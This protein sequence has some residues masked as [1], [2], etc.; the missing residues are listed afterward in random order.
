MKIQLAGKFITL[1]PGDRIVTPITVLNLTQHHAIFIGNYLRRPHFIENKIGHGVRLVSSEIFF[2]EN[3]KITRVEQFMG[4]EIE[5]NQLI[6]K[7]FQKLGGNYHLLLY[8]CE[9]FANEIQFN[10]IF[11]PQVKV[12][13]FLGFALLVMWSFSND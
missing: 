11:S 2:I 3:P 8:N 5:R 10:K 9:H 7:A 13:L 6:S 4:S 12:G 1:L